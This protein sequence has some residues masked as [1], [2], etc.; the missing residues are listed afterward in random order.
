MPYH[1]DTRF[2]VSLPRSLPPPGLERPPADCLAEHL[3]EAYRH[4]AACEDPVVLDLIRLA[5]GYVGRA[6]PPTA[7]HAAEEHWS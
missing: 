7:L 5:L 1:D 3:I 4:A 6:Y 2:P